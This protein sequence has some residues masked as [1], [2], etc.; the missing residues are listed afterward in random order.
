MPFIKSDK[1]N[2]I[3][4]K[5]IAITATNGVYG[6]IFILKKMFPAKLTQSMDL[7][8]DI[9]EKKGKIVFYRD[10]D[11]G[12]YQ[13]NGRTR[14]ITIPKAIFAEI[15]PELSNRPLIGFVDPKGHLIFD[16]SEGNTNDL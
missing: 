13:I 5:A 8:L 3:P 12:T 9:E 15:S 1:L 14:Q 11:K 16:Y 7:F 4:Q 2:V 10:K 6:R